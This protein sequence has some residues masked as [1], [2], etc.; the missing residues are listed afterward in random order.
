VQGYP[1]HT[2]VRGRFVMKDGE[3]VADSKGWGR[4]VKEIQQ[5]PE[6]VVRNADKTTAAIIAGYPQG[7]AR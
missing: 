7:G 6:P 3:L 2:L 1:L 5:M 4:S